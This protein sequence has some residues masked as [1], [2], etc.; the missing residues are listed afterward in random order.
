MDK[1]VGTKDTIHRLIEKIWVIIEDQSQTTAKLWD[2]RYED[3]EKIG[4]IY[5]Y[6]TN[7]VDLVSIGRV[8]IV[9][10]LFFNNLIPSSILKFDIGKYHTDPLV[11]LEVYLKKLIMQAQ[12]DDDTLIRPCIDIRFG[13]WEPTLFGKKMVYRSDQEPRLDDRPVVKKMD[14]ISELPFPDFRNS[15][16]MPLT[17]RFYTTISNVLRGTG[18]EVGF[19][20]WTRGQFG[21]LWQLVGYNNLLISLIDKPKSVHEA[22]Q[23]LTEVRKEYHTYRAKLAGEPVRECAFVDDE[24]NCP[25]L[26]PEQYREFVFPYEKA[27]YDFCRGISRWHSCGDCTPLLSEIKKLGD[28]NKLSVSALWDLERT[29]SFFKDATLEICLDALRDVFMAEPQSIT[30][31]MKKIVETCKNFRISRFYV[32]ANALQGTGPENADSDLRKITQWV[33]VAKSA[34][35][36]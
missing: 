7:P 2:R 16:L 32:R 27:M 6:S 22:M 35:A 14:Q 5:W 26:S 17:H 34:S 23:F 20:R 15:G 36:I 33:R 9:A 11:Y 19:P 29:C 28:I 8:P 4:N 25:T 12:L 21:I 1:K 3:K 13:V 10:D 24:V 31:R 18:V 30:N